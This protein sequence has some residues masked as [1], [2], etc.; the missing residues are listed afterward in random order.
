MKNLNEFIT[1]A[2][3]HFGI[4]YLEK[5]DITE[6]I[7]KGAQ[8]DNDV[9]KAPLIV[10]WPN[11]NTPETSITAFKMKDNEWKGRET[12]KTWNDETLF[13]AIQDDFEYCKLF[14]NDEN[15][16]KIVGEEKVR[17]LYK[18]AN[19]KVNSEK[20]RDRLDY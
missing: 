12:G 2:N 20:L 19:N 5:E 17:E 15:L 7:I 4:L 18:I 11:K 1:E 6:D 8:A 10:V 14:I 3:K 9:R 13:K 16:R